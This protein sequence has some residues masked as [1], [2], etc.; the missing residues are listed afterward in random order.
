MNLGPEIS[1]RGYSRSFKLVYHW[2]TGY[3]FLFAV[4]SNYGHILAVCEIGS[5]TLK[6]GLGVL[7]GRCK[8]CRSI[9]H[10]RF[11]IGRPL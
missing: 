8:W 11:S 9:D 7:Q 1:V 6:T 4:Y 2:K 3:G 5:V 10:V